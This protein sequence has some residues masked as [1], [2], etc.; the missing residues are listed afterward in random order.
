[1]AMQHD[2]QIDPQAVSEEKMLV[3]EV[4]D[5][6]IVPDSLQSGID[7]VAKEQTVKELTKEDVYRLVPKDT[8]MAYS[9]RAALAQKMLAD[10]ANGGGDMQIDPNAVAEYRMILSPASDVPAERMILTPE[11]QPKS[12]TVHTEPMIDG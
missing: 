7:G 9:E 4:D 1:E 6:A 10:E 2:G 8:M 3:T 5:N 11:P 12:S